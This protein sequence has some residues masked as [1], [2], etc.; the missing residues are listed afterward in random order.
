MDKGDER[1][2]T[3]HGLPFPASAVLKL[4]TAPIRVRAALV[5]IAAIIY[6]GGAIGFYPWIGR[7]GIGLAVLP[8]LVV[9]VSF[10]LMPAAAVA[11][12]S[13]PANLLMFLL[14]GDPHPAGLLGSNFWM[15]QAV[16]L[17]VGSVAGM[18]SDLWRRLHTELGMRRRTEAKLEYMARHD[19]LTGTFNRYS[20]D[21]ILRRE[22]ARAVRHRRPIGF[23]MIDVNRFKEVNDRF[24]HQMGDRVLESIAEILIDQTRESDY[25]FRY[26]G[27]EFLVVLPEAE[28]DASEVRHRIET[29]VRRRNETNPLLDFPVTLAIGVLHIE[30][31]ATES[32]DDILAELDRRMYEDKRASA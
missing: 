31:T 20:L 22:I 10:G 6:G 29:V 2:R 12:L 14:A 9:G 19:P 30:E 23:L 7:A 28:R 18:M 25:V 8:V 3:S 13:I 17:L 4:S 27:D 11:V 15:S 16:F 5:S 24:G 21:E 1:T 26:G 32:P